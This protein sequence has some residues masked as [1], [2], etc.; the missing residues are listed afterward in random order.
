MKGIE[1]L[2]HLRRLNLS[3][4]RIEK[5]EHIQA[6][7]LLEELNLENNHISRITNL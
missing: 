6:C 1:E 3:Y 5:I 7:K 4:N 2:V